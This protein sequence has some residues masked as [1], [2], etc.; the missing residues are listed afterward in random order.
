MV[1][2]YTYRQH[3]GIADAVIKC[4]DIG[5]ALLQ[6]KATPER[7]ITDIGELYHGAWHQVQP[8]VVWPDTFHI[9]HR[10]RAKTRPR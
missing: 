7:H 1:P 9:P 10:T 6:A 3:P 8:M 2:S 4:L 5:N